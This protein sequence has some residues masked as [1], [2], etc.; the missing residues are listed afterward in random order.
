[1]ANK[2]LALRLKQFSEWAPAQVSHTTERGRPRRHV[3]NAHDAIVFWS[4]EVLQAFA[5]ANPYM[6][7]SPCVLGPHA[8]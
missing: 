3:E 7:A 4:S 2:Y 8:D 6:T 1:V 5:S